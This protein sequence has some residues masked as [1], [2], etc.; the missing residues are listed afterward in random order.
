MLGEIKRKA[1]PFEG[2]VP[3]NWVFLGATENRV[4]RFRYYETPEGEYYYTLQKLKKSREPRIEMRQEDGYTFARRSYKR[5]M[6]EA[7]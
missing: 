5:R 2:P 4:Y 6:Y 3:D 1:K 7:I